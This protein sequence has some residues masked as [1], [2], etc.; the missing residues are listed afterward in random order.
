MNNHTA[1]HFVLQLGSLIS[2]Y[3]SLAFFIVLTF[4]LINLRFPE[5][6]SLWDVESAASSIR[7][8]FAMVL[9]FFP[10][11]LVLTRMVN[12]NRRASNDTSYLGLTKWLIYLSLLVGG[13]V[14]LG[15]MVAVI[16]G[17]LEG[18]LTTKFILKALTV[19]VIT[20]S[21]FF[22]YLKDAQGYWLAREK[23]SFVYAAVTSSVMLVILVTAL[24]HIPNPAVVREMNIDQKMV[25]DLQN[26]QWDIEGY[27]QQNDALPL[28]LE[29]LY[30]EFT[31]SQPPEGRPPYK[32]EI[33]DASGKY[34]L[35]ATFAYDSTYFG[36]SYVDRINTIDFRN[37]Y[38]NNWDYKAGEWCF[39]KV[40]KTE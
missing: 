20:G 4:G 3:L 24:A 14:L 32:F 28:S 23:M 31:P 13:L 26:I 37:S 34:Q 33:L 40:V 27:Y 29:Q 6:L 38:N 39:E 17:L 30:G 7:I 25:N 5:N 15:D 21:A 1:K 9:V 36:N 10:T 8:G 16:I 19:F 22:Y 12:Q 2:L 11:Y 35:C 18:E